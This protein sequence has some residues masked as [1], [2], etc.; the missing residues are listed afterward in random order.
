MARHLSRRARA[1]VRWTVC[2][3]P[4][5]VQSAGEDPLTLRATTAEPATR[6]IVIGA[7]AGGLP[8]LRTVIA[9]LPADLAAAVLVVVH[10]PAT[11]TSLLPEILA[12]TTALDVEPARDSLQLRPGL[13]LVAPPNRHLVVDGGHVAL[14]DGAREN[15]HRP[16]VDP[17]FR[18]A[19]AAFG[20]RC[21]AVVLSGARDDGAAGMAEVRRRGGVA[22]VQ[23]P[24][25]ALHPDMPANAMAASGVACALPAAEIGPE[26][27]R[28]T[29]GA[30]TLRVTA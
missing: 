2:G 12:R 11:G 19:A 25:E 21:C 10:V 30:G 7:S 15:G 13:V 4:I 17:L 3:R 8:P 22:I 29:A 9:A 28:L 14:Q 24:G 23:D 6:L 5:G 26:L 20:D 16:A 1:G 18:S 27:V